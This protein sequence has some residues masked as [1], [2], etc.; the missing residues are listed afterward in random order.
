VKDSCAKRGFV[1]LH[2]FARSVDPQLGLNTRDGDSLPS[3]SAVGREKLA[4]KQ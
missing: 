1:E 4:W 2:C 3:T